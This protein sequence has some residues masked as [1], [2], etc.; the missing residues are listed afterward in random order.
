MENIKMKPSGIEWLGDIPSDWEVVNIGGM[1]TVR[2]Q[3][4]SDRDY[5]PLSVTKQGVLPQLD[6][7]AKTNA[8]DDR[9]LV[10]K[11][12]FAIN[13]RSDRRGSC[14]VSEYDGSVSLINT[15]LKPREQMHSGYYNWLFHTVQ[16]GDEFYKNGHGIVDDLWTTNWQDMKKMRV[17]FPSLFEQQKIAVFLDDRCSEIDALMTDI[18]SQIDTLEQ[19]KR[20]LI[21][22]TVTK[23]LYSDVA[24]KDSN[25]EWIGLVP[26]HWDVSKIKYHLKRNEPKNPGGVQVLSVYREYGVIPKDSR[27]DNHNVTSQDTSKYKYVRPG[28]LVINKMKAWQ[29]SLAVS[30]YEGIVSPAYF[31]YNFTD[32]RF[33]KKYFHFLIRSCYK[34]EFRRISG[35]IRDGQWDLPAE[36]FANELVLLPPIDEQNHIVDYLDTK[37]AEID[38]AITDKKAQLETLEQYKK[39]LIYEY[40]TG[41]KQVKENA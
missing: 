36:G 32:S 29:G 41:K 9:K 15:V 19:Y 10:K 11:G 21:T 35:G 33:N 14:G 25:I 17:P 12:D 34:D 20:S 30:E 5:P 3:K 8:H 37:C 27:D 18:Q 40:V 6:F 22:E 1:Y 28:D 24:M 26:Q 7:V 31:I 39:S 23:G 4:V 13:S 38:S 16:F 2:N